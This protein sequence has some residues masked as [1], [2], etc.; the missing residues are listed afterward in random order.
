MNNR[1]T[2]PDKTNIWPEKRTAKAYWWQKKLTSHRRLMEATLDWSDP[3]AG[4]YWLDLG[5]GSGALTIEIWERTRGTV[6]GIA[7]VDIAD[8]N[9]R[10]YK[11]FQRKLSPVPGNKI[12]FYCHDFSAGLQSFSDAEFDHVVSGLAVPYAQSYSQETHRWTS[13]AYDRLMAETYRVLK[14]GGRFVFS[15]PIPDPVWSH[16]LVESAGSICR[17]IL[18]PDFLKSSLRMLSYGKWLKEQARIGRFHY[19]PAETVEERLK[20]VGF[21]SVDVRTSFAGQAF[22]FRAVKPGA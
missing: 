10:I 14:P 18:S 9:S 7:G 5:C 3:T 19:L 16:V 1:S 13:E 6:S 15:S 8:A 4:E 12:R 20:D 11:A 22:V 2:L 21:G 17:N